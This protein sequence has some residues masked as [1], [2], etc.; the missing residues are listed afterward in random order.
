MTKTAEYTS[1][2]AGANAMVKDIT[3]M[4]DWDEV[5]KTSDTV[6]T[7][8]KNQGDGK[9]VGLRV[10]ARTSDYP[11]I[12]ALGCNGA[13]EYVSSVNYHTRYVA[14]AYGNG[15]FAMCTCLYSMPYTST[16]YNAVM[17][18]STNTN[19]L[20]GD[21]GYC[22][23]Y[24]AS[25]SY[26]CFSKSS[27]TEQYTMLHT[28]DSAN[29]GAGVLLHSPKTGDVADK[30]MIL[31]AMPDSNYACLDRVSFNGIQYTRLGRILVPVE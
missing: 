2:A 9:Y 30:V 22:T 12:S 28:A 3:G 16:N 19:I 31:T 8:K 14:Y 21:T 24:S 18:I 25:S 23:F 10:E 29:I 7:F 17:G 15:F 13:T 27:A 4:F 11:R 26:Y 20:T 1:N 5:E 6:T